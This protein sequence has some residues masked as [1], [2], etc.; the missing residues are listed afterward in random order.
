ME[1]SKEAGAARRVE[2]WSGC[3]TF[4]G[5]GI[6]LERGAGGGGESATAVEVRPIDPP[7]HTSGQQNTKCWRV[8]TWGCGFGYASD[9]G[10]G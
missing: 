7:V 4:D 8:R 9:T 5:A 6:A 3:R 1:A 2:A 10:F